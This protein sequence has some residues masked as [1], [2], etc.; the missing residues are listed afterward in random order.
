[1]DQGFDLPLFLVVFTLV[2]LGII[3]VSVVP[4]VIEVLRHRRQTA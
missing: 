1:M 3:I 4:P 2:I